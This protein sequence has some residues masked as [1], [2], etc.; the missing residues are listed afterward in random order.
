MC[1]EEVI[2]NAP[3]RLIYFGDARVRAVRRTM[4]VPVFSHALLSTFVTPTLKERYVPRGMI[5]PA[6]SHALSKT[7]VTPTLKERYVPHGMIVW[8]R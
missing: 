6:F 8:V 2:S 3:G 7:F 4:T 5:V 1:C